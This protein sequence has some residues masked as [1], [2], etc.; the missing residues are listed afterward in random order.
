MNKN[1]MTILTIAIPLVLTNCAHQRTIDVDISAG[2][3]TLYQGVVPIY[4]TP[5]QTAAKG[6]GFKKGSNQTPTGQYTVTK[7][8]KHRY[9]KVLRLSGYQGNVRG[10]LLHKHYGALNGTA[11]CICPHK[12]IQMNTLFK[13]VKD[14]DRIVIRR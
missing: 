6:I 1:I 3:L 4:R 9:G 10:I 2:R 11:G 7:N 14:G 13:L 12:E 5:V 8:A